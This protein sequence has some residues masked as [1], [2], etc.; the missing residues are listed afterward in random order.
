MM[1][2]EATASAQTPAPAAE[3]L[4]SR[5][6]RLAA[7]LASRGFPAADRAALKRALPGRSPPLAFYRLWLRHIDEDLP[8]ES[9]TSDWATL[10]WGMAAS[11]T[12]PHRPDRSLGSALAEAKYSEARLERLLDAPDDLTRRRLFASLVRF[13][14]AKGECFDWTQAAQLLLTRDAG[15][16]DGVHRRVATDY[17]RHQSRTMKE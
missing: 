9:Q 1:D 6:G 15:A 16:R 2:R 10:A 12:S 5:A 13:M 11:G 17:Y 7:V 14:A 3:N 8:A 4:R